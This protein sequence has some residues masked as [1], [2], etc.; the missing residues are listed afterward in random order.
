MRKLEFDRDV[1]KKQ[2]KLDRYI[3]VAP[4]VFGGPGSG[5]NPEGGSSDDD[6]A[7]KTI[8]ADAVWSD[9]SGDMMKIETR[10]DGSLLATGN[11]YQIEADSKAEMLKKLEKD[12]FKYLGA[13]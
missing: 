8:Y 9:K 1:K 2:S 4:E 7:D 11:D 12:G 5:R 3:K 10:R 13:D 6:R